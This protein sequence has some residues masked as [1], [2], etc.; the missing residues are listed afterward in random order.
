MWAVN[1]VA[2]L[3]PSG[4]QEW[5]YLLLHVTQVKGVEGL[6]WSPLCALLSLW[7]DLQ[8]PGS[9]S[10]VAGETA[11]A[12]SR[13]EGHWDRTGRT[14]LPILPRGSLPDAEGMGWARPA[15]RRPAAS[16]AFSASAERTEKN[17]PGTGCRRAGDQLRLQ[18]V[19]QTGT[20]LWP[21][22][23]LGRLP[24][25]LSQDRIAKV[26]LSLKQV[27]GTAISGL[28]LP[29]CQRQPHHKLQTTENKV[30]N[31]LSKLDSAPR[32]AQHLLRT[33]QEVLF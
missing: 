2:W 6:C 21:S 5:V 22:T 29:P 13:R 30:A 27:R 1:Q 9:G 10:R 33:F 11:G 14:G 17:A 18:V 7:P 20:C 12:F 23:D 8:R 25:G 32:T 31:R 24:D 15:G 19:A 26:V 4:N 3:H 28:Y 16:A